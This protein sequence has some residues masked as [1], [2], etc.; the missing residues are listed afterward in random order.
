MNHPHDILA[1]SLLGACLTDE[2]CTGTVVSE[3]FQDRW[4]SWKTLFT[5]TA[6]GLISKFP[7]MPS[8]ALAVWILI[9][10]YQEGQQ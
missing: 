9:M 4:R 2:D 7:Q 1:W 6:D 3:V 10:S 8:E 5:V